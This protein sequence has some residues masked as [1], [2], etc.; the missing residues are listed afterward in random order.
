[1]KNLIFILALTLTIVGC[2]RTSFDTNN[3]TSTQC[4]KIPPDIP[5]MIGP[6]QPTV[7]NCELQR[8]Y[9]RGDVE[10]VRDS[11]G[12]VLC[13]KYTNRDVDSVPPNNSVNVRAK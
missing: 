13:I 10:V 9:E 5:K 12:N 8:A 4:T 6:N 11:T 2:N 3:I 1:M 7:W